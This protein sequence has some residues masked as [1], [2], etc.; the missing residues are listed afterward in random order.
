VLSFFHASIYFPY[1][2][3]FKYSARVI[4]KIQSSIEFAVSWVDTVLPGKYLP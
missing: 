1:N 2:L 3:P 4:G